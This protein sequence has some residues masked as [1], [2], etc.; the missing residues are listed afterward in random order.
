MRRPAMLGACALVSTVSMSV[1][2]Q[3]RAAAPAVEEVVVT[4]TSIRGIASAGSPSIA[5]DHEAFVE[6]GVAT[7]SDLGRSLPQV[8]N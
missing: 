6:T 3:E 5:L 8:I 4:G 7:S 2:A 1:H